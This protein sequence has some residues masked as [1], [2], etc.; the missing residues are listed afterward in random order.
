[1]E[2]DC[3]GLYTLAAQDIFLL[4]QHDDFSDLYATVSFYEIYCS[5]L[6]DLLNNREILHCREDNKQKVCIQGLTE[7]HVQN[8]EEL[9]DVMQEGTKS[10]TTGKTGAN[11]DSSRSHAVLTITIKRR[12]NS[13]TFGVMSFIDLAGSE[14]GADTTDN[15]K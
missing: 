2:E 10:R 6:F 4:L 9:F 7:I 8:D 13:K 14:R 15:G 12:S 11:V 1:M 3:P 5:K